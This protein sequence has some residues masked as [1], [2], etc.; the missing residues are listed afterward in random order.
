MWKKDASSPARSQS[1]IDEAGQGENKPSHVPLPSRP[2]ISFSINTQSSQEQGTRPASHKCQVESD[3]QRKHPGNPMHN[4]V[5]EFSWSV[6]THSSGQSWRE[7]EMP[8]DPACEKAPGLY[9][10]RTLHFRTVLTVS[11]LTHR[12]SFS[13][14]CGHQLWAKNP[15]TSG[16]TGMLRVCKKRHTE[17]ADKTC[18]D[19]HRNFRSETNL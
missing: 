2:F 9:V 18:F 14:V 11:A 16:Q 8:A 15:Q 10:L 17:N 6:G 1:T 3:R 7:G 5:S 19:F 13:Y 4:A 12:K